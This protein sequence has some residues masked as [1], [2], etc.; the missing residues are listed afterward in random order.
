MFA[1]KLISRL[2]SHPSVSA[3]ALHS[4]DSSLFDY[5]L[6]DVKVS[7]DDVLSTLKS[8]KPS[9]SVSHYC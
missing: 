3:D 9:T 1:S 7:A 5:Q 8:L 2:T 6:S 4:L